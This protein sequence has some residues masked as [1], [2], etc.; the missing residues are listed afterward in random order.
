M[1]ISCRSCKSKELV[2]ILSLGE[3]YVSD[4]IDGDNKPVAYPLSLVLCNNCGLLQLK[5]DVPPTALYTDRYGYRSGINKTMREHLVE[6][7]R[8]VEKMANPKRGDIVIDIGCN[9]GTLLKSYTTVGLIRVGYDPITKFGLYFNGT[10]IKFVN[11]YFNGRTYKKDFGD[12]KAKIITAIS[13]FYDLEEPNEFVSDLSKVIHDDGIIVI[14]QNYLAEMLKQNAFDNIVHEHLEYYSLTSMENLLTR[15]D[16]TV[17]DV[18]INDI[19]GGSFRT[20]ICRRGAREVKESVYKLRKYEKKLGL[21]EEKIY[22][23]FVDRISN[24]K[25]KLLSLIEGEVKQGKRIYIYGASTRGNAILQYCGID[26]RLIMKAVERNP[27]KWGK[28][29]A[30]TGIPIIS[31]EEGRKERPDY[32]LVLPWF[33]K[34]EFIERETEYLQNG[35]KLIF[36]LPQIEVIDKRQIDK[37]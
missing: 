18:L 4:F 37:E 12:R 6:I 24:I 7:V 33:F 23:D 30:S 2:D 17:F 35:G 1:I 14:Q 13:M 10:D 16:L 31:E 8:S 15:H 34:Q 3:Q 21:S 5:D 29:I 36:P 11:D 9:D 25:K 32:M 20:Y 19:N 27:E 26:K 28:R 22:R